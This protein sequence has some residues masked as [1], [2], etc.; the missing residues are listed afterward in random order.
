MENPQNGWFVLEN[1]TKMDDW[2]VYP[3]LWN[4][5]ICTLSTRSLAEVLCNRNLLLIVLS[6]VWQ[7][8]PLDKR[9]VRCAHQSQRSKRMWCRERQRQNDNMIGFEILIRHPRN[10]PFQLRTPSIEHSP[11][12]LAKHSIKTVPKLKVIERYRKQHLSMT[13]TFGSILLD[14]KT[15]GCHLSVTTMMKIRM[16]G[17]QRAGADHFQTPSDVTR[18]TS[19]TWLGVNLQMLLEQKNV[20]S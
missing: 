9:H 11:Q 13:S 7:S 5:P 1:P 17:R 12:R 8:M 14:Q 16:R 6:Q 2:G 15:L 20:V 19:V 18:M 10:N 4:P 3:Y